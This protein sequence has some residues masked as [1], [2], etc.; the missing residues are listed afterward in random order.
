MSE[1]TLLLVV[2]AWDICLDARGNIAMATPPYSRA[3]SVANALRLFAG[4]LWYNTAA[5]IP[6]F[7]EILGHAPPVSAFEQYMVRAAL[8]V[9]GVA[10]AQCT[11]S[12]IEGRVLTGSVTFTSDDGTT[13][14]VPLA[15][16]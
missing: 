7:E 5:G 12:G 1:N 8:T 11:I 6:Y 16:L 13:G 10:E 9:P 2:D 14:T 4:E 15:S 3:Q